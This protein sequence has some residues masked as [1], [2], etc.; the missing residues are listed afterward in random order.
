MWLGEPES[1]MVI[2]SNHNQKSM[3]SSVNLKSHLAI[4]FNQS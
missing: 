3:Y 4:P 2:S 1:H